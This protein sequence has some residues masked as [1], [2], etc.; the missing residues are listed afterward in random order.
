[1]KII[2]TAALTAALAGCATPG[3]NYPTYT[4]KHENGDAYIECFLAVRS[5]PCV[6]PAKQM[7]MTEQQMIAQHC[8]AVRK[9][10][11]TSAL[12]PAVVSTNPQQK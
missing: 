4:L 10:R 6:G 7:G 5:Y 12:C 11:I 1:M 9:M 3:L 8:W 2:I